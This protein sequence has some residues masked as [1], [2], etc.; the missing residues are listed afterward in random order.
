MLERFLSTEQI[1]RV[2]KYSKTLF[3]VF[4]TI[5]IIYWVLA[6]S[7]GIQLFEF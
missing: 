7:V 3:A 6:Y 1:G 2:T 4:L 5:C